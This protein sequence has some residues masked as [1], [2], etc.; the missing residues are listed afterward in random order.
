MI[1]V[2]ELLCST[3]E[4]TNELEISSGYEEVFSMSQKSDVAA[5]A[6]G[7]ISVTLLTMQVKSTLIALYEKTLEDVLKMLQQ[8]LKSSRNIDGSIAFIMIALA[9]VCEHMQCYLIDLMNSSWP[10]SFSVSTV[11]RACEAIDE[12]YCF[13][14]NL[15]SLKY[16]H[17]TTKYQQI[18]QSPCPSATQ[19][20]DAVIYGMID[21]T[22]EN[23]ECNFFSLILISS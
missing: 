18:L 14:T 5:S 22:R 3:Y 16:R 10:S 8:R 23:C 6:S 1:T 9:L 2:I 20:I 15:F 13:L 7:K 12:R 19:D 11:Q 4:L 17:L 21:L